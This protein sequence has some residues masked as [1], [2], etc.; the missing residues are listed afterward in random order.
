MDVPAVTF[1]FKNKKNP[2]IPPA[3]GRR[4]YAN[5]AEF[6]RISCLEW[7]QCQ[8]RIIFKI[9]FRPICYCH[10]LFSLAEQIPVEINLPIFRPLDGTTDGP[11]KA[12]H[13]RVVVRKIASRSDRRLATISRSAGIPA[14]SDLFVTPAVFPSGRI[15]QRISNSIEVAADPQ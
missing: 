7:Q 9:K 8:R 13:F 14:G 10:V 6:Q 11:R 5:V 3:G 1:F 12:A 15:N 2:N 4:L